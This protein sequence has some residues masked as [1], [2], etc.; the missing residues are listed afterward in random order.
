MIQVRIH[1]RGGQGVVTSAELIAIAAFKS[2]LY[3]QAFPFFGVERSG[4]PIQAFARISE[5]PITVR[6]HIYEPDIII[7]QDATLLES[8]DILFGAKKNTKILVNTSSSAE[9]IANKIKTEKIQSFMPATKNIFVTDATKIA[10]E[11][12]GR[13]IMN[14]TILGVFAKFTKLISLNSL[15]EAISEKLNSKGEKI[16]SANIAA[17]KRAYNEH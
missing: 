7:V 5:T 4:A 11:V 8:D 1:G 10:L 16:I 3:A 6:E 9:E 13:N 2:G 12:L 17:A 14:T 15:H